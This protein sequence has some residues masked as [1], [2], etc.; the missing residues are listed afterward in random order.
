MEVSVTCSFL[1][2]KENE[3][4]DAVIVDPTVELSM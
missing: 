4:S 1:Q 2:V 3:M